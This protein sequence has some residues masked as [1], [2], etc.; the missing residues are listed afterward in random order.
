MIEANLHTEIAQ[1]EKN[2]A[3]ANEGVADF[4]IKIETEN[5]WILKD[6][7]KQQAELDRLNRELTQNTNELNECH[8]K[9]EE[10]TKALE[11]A[12]SLLNNRTNH[13]N[14]EVTRLEGEIELFEQVVEL[15]ETGVANTVEGLKKE[16]DEEIAKKTAPQFIESKKG[17]DNI[18]KAKY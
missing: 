6:L 10:D 16:V 13:Y 3:N 4:Q 9:L 5:H 15:Y 17:K 7:V 2:E 12:E 8:A 1:N 18:R 11:N 14:D